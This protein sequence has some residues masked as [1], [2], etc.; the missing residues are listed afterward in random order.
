M[1][2]IKLTVSAF[3]PYAGTTVLNMDELGKSG[4]YLITG[5]T[6]AGKTTIFDAMVF[7]L[8]GRA[9]GENRE[10]SMLRS[11]YASPDTPTMVELVFEYAG[12]QYTVRRNPE[13]E[14]PAKRGG[15]RTIEKADAE[16][17]YP[18]G[19]VLT[20]Q[21]EVNEA[22]RGIIGIDDGQFMQ[23]AMIAQGD[24]LKLLLA[25][26]E[27]RKKIFRR[28]FRTEPFDRLQELLKKE[29]NKI[30]QELKE[31]KAVVNSQIRSVRCAKDDLCSRKE[32]EKAAGEELPFTD[33]MSLIEELILQDRQEEA[34]L[35][36]QIEQKEERLEKVTSEI[37]KAQAFAK[38][39]TSLKEAE[40]K[41]EVERPRKAQLLMVQSEAEKQAVEVKTLSE[42]LSQAGKDGTAEC[43]GTGHA[44]EKL[45]ADAVTAGENG[46]EPEKENTERRLVQTAAVNWKTDRRTLEEWIAGLNASL[47]EYQELDERKKKVM[48]LTETIAGAE[49]RREQVQKEKDSLQRDTEHKKKEREQLAHA[50][51]E[52]ERLRAEQEKLQEKSAALDALIKMSD[53]CRELKRECEE[54]QEAYR[55]ARD[56]AEE[57]KAAYDRDNRRYLD[58]QAGIL[59]E[60][61]KDGERCPVCGAL[62]HP[63]PAHREA[64]APDRKQLDRQKKQ[65]EQAQEQADLA[66]TQ[67][68]QAAG[69]LS[70]KQ[71]SLTEQA[72][73]LLSSVSWKKEAYQTADAPGAG[74]GIS[75]DVMPERSEGEDASGE[76]AMV[77]AAAEGEKADVEERLAACR[78]HMALEEQRIERREA[79]DKE[80][81][82]AENRQE[83]LRQ[84]L[85]E[86]E[87]GIDSDTALKQEREES[88]EQLAERLYFESGGAARQ[89]LEQ[90]R[91]L[92]ETLRNAAEQARQKAA[93]C[94]KEIAALEGQIGHLKEQLS[95]VSESSEEEYGEQ[96]ERLLAEKKALLDEKQD[97]HARRSG[98]EEIREELSAK[99]QQIAKTEEHL[100]WMQSLSDTANGNLHGKEK[101][102]LETY[103]QMT[104]FDRILARANTRFMMM[105]SGQYELERSRQ[106]ENRVSQSG[107]DLNVIDHYNG[108]CR[109]VKTLSGGESFQASLSLALGLSDEIQAS[110]GGIRLDTMFV[111]EG[112]GSLDEEALE[113]AM[114]ALTGLAEANRLVGMISH[115][116]ALKERI[117]RQ[118]IVTKSADGGS[119]AKIVC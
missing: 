86:L 108:T 63:C 6:G 112:F 1:R 62:E 97:V 40:E 67:A 59:A 49:K 43:S 77:R 24:F 71:K 110:A 30:R 87:K 107:L 55:R 3:G 102:M 53:E 76:P 5:D 68:G 29:V 35:E 50:G 99:A 80:I 75:D 116:T 20:K 115:V 28:V 21:R 64:D 72:E 37:G 81:P 79:L 119:S 73:K 92:K 91:A 12:K 8:Y 83:C 33:M 89:R 38:A 32:L 26:T 105:S 65:A 17:R 56:N 22:V 13:Y 66:S 41:L 7:A 78:E 47:P 118:I 82:E 39:R 94:D 70:Q 34:R 42:W 60:T 90:L 85:A 114:K 113:Q 14:R 16:L 2:P 103:V 9:S 96:R 88:L 44:G 45:S 69:M 117:D 23:I 52:R 95:E 48:A 15:G 101:I 84:K 51:E 104:Y 61:L 109:S 111:D 36:S 27:E 18:D 98:N 31:Q 58:A 19:R 11:Q 57:K 4:L 100:S 10:P 93:A 25:T 54:R 106:A 46:A 74:A